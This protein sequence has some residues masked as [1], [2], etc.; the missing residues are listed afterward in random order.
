M[1]VTV[2]VA[3]KFGISAAAKRY[4]VRGGAPGVHDDVVET[5]YPR[6]LGALAL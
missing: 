4:A 6:A 5:L 1:P 2:A 3:L